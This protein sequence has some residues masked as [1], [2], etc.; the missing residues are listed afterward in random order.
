MTRVLITGATGFVGKALCHHLAQS[1]YLVRAALRCQCSVPACVAEAV[2]VGDIATTT[3]WEAALD[4]VE[5]VI[6]VA[7]KAHVQQQTRESTAVCVKT[8]ACGT[9]RLVEASAHAGVRRF[10]YLS[11]VKVNG[12][13]IADHA[14]S[15]VD[16][17]RPRDVYGTSKWLG[18]R[19]VNRTAARTGLEV[20]IVRSP[21]VYGPGVRANFLRLMRWVDKEWPLP[22]GA[23]TNTRSLVSIWNLCDLLRH[24]L[25]SPIAPG[26]TWMVSDGEDLSTPDLIRRLGRAMHRRV[27]LL[28]IPV[29]LLR[30]VGGVLGRKAE[31]ARLCGSLAV[32]VAP[33]R[34]ALRWS[35]PMTV[36][37]ALART[38]DWYLS[39]R[40]SRDLNQ[41]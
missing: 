28:P 16:E 6:H 22:L 29:A 2:V 5:A 35:A 27:R 18:E 34:D 7:G 41:L 39:E 1:G 20:A 38:V 30:T 12:E 9:R 11:T 17:P 40:R 21:L 10:V 8:N 24:I 37:E 32:D 33:T 4:G 25:T 14:Y 3:N 36:D 13:E 15:S 23:V 26:H 31:I 19:H